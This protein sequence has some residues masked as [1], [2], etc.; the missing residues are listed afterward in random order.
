MLTSLL[1]VPP[2]VA[3][4]LSLLGRGYRP[5]LLL[6]A[7]ALALVAFGYAAWRRHWRIAPDWPELLLALASV[8]VVVGYAI[9][10]ALPSL[11]PIAY[12][13]DAVMHY[14]LTDF[15][16]THQRIPVAADSSS[17]VAH[18]ALYPF[19]A[20]LL[21]ALVSALGRV[22]PIVALHPLT[23]IF[24][25]VALLFAYG[26]TS[27]LL[28]GS[29][30]RRIVSVTAVTLLFWPAQYLVRNQFGWTDFFFPQ[31]LSHVWL[32][33]SLYWTVRLSRTRDALWAVPL[34]L[35]LAA[36][37]VGY[38][39]WAFAPLA[40]TTLAIAALRSS[41]WR[42]RL[43]LASGAVGPSLVLLALYL[44]DRLDYFGWTATVPGA[45]VRP[46]LA[47]LGETFVVLAGAGLIVAIAS[48]YWPFAI[49]T[50]VL[51]A[52]MAAAYA[53]AAAKLTSQYWADKFWYQMVLLMGIG[54]AVLIG[55]H[56]R[57]ARDFGLR[58]WWQAPV[59]V[60]IVL[61]SLLP[62]RMELQ[63][64]M[65][66]PPPFGPD[67]YAAARWAAA[68]LPGT[69]L[70]FVN[71]P[72]VNA[73]WVHTAIMRQHPSTIRQPTGGRES[74]GYADWQYDSRTGDY[75]YMQ[76]IGAHP[77][78][79][80]EVLYRS[81]DIVVL[82]RMQAPANVR[83]DWA[84]IRPDGSGD[85]PAPIGSLY[86]LNRASASTARLARG[87]SIR[88][89]LEVVPRAT[90][91]RD[92]LLAAHLRDRD[93]RTVANAE[94]TLTAAMAD[95]RR[96]TPESGKIGLSLQVPADA[97]AGVYQ[98]ELFALTLPDLQPDRAYFGDSP[99]EARVLL[100]P[101]VLTPPEVSEQPL[102]PARPSGARLGEAIALAGFDLAA[103][104][105][106]VVRGELDW[107]ALAPPSEDYT[108]F[109]HVLDST[110]QIVGQ[111]DRQP[112]DGRY[113]TS[114]WRAG[115]YL[116]DPFEVRLPAGTPPGEYRVIAGM[117]LLRTQ[118][119]LPVAGGVGAAGDHVVLGQL[120]LAR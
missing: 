102:A 20:S 119:R 97:P 60:L 59:A 107:Q 101:F 53:A 114:V 30:L 43:A 111:S 50:L 90:V 54:V 63:R 85:L 87:G 98:I 32:I 93:G 92:T 82:R 5:W 73:Y 116:R 44:K 10:I 79:D 56:V 51:L 91:G 38:T 57:Y 83:G 71:T 48:R 62:F 19:S 77:L 72:R 42:R 100:A 4:A 105:G 52:Q 28:A 94:Y 8:G 64:T 67:H 14:T 104:E 88:L 25:G 1:G 78:A 96:A 66:K 110:G 70:A 2:L 76:I 34:A 58:G 117:Y 31:V 23:A 9:W 80:A 16:L 108:V 65:L 26:V 61:A 112:L 84:L 21:A 115:E 36:G 74:Y 37:A 75:A 55:A 13:I 69:R 95:A 118:Q 40:G 17:Y 24:L 35:S 33:G 3:F 99:K 47:A 86:W 106:L 15:L 18:F 27:R 120:M 7:A 81:G 12:S 11:F 39:V 68:N 49:Y 41:S 6:V 89:E 46:S 22:D 113:P 103:G 29:P 109:I 45:V